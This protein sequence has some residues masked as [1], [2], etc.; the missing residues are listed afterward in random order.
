MRFS[1]TLRLNAKP[2][3]WEFYVPY[4]QLKRR[5]AN[6]KYIHDE[7]FIKTHSIPNSSRD[8]GEGSSDDERDIESHGDNVRPLRRT[9]SARVLAE[10]RADSE[11]DL[12]TYGS[13][14]KGPAFAFDLLLPID[15][16][17]GDARASFKEQEKIFFEVLENSKLQVEKFFQKL[18]NTL[19]SVTTEIEE[20]AS[21]IMVQSDAGSHDEMEVAPLLI[22]NI[23]TSGLLS[24]SEFRRRCREH[25]IELG[26]AINFSNLNRA[27]FD[28]IL[29]KHDKCTGMSKREAFMMKLDAESLFVDLRDIKALQDTTARVYA[30]LFMNGNVDGAEKELNEHL[31]DLIV[32]DRSTIWQQA[33]RTERRVSVFHAIRG[34][35]DVDLGAAASAVVWRPQ[36]IPVLTAILLFFIILA[37]PGVIP[38]LLTEDGPNYPDSTLQAAHRCLALT[39]AVV[40]L[41]ASEGIPL[42]VTSFL[43]VPG[44]ILLRVFIGSS[45]EPLDAHSAS[46]EVFHNLSSDTLLLIICVYA[47]GAAL[48][49]FDIDKVVATAVLS[50]VRKPQVLLLAVMGLGVVVSM[51]VSN[52]AAPVLLNSVMMPTI[53]GLRNTPGSRP[54]VECLLLGIMASSNIGGFASPISS[55]QSAVALGLLRGENSISFA[56]WLVAALPLCAVMVIAFYVALF[57]I[58]RP[59]DYVLPPLVIK[60]EKFERPHYIVSAT[61]V[62]TVVLWACHPLSKSFGSPGVVAV[63]PILALFGSGILIKEDFNNLPW[64]VV[65][66][67]AGGVVL[68]AAVKSCKLLDLIALKFLSVLDHGDLRLTYSVFCLFMALV[69]NFV[70]HTVSAIVVLP[71]VFSIGVSLGH[72][73]LM[74][75]AGTFAASSAMALPISS[76]PNISAIQ[77]EDETG[78]AYLSTRDILRIGTLMT[79]LATVVLLTIGY[80]I[81]IWLKL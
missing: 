24:P 29:K 72:P 79:I 39:A 45:G 8:A 23:S 27:A 47:L 13:V 51:F 20:E 46:Q 15:A 50:R 58:Y 42:Y 10:I 80:N 66:L 12:Q 4:D 78:K 57:I 81:M 33:L 49:K 77:V 16:T 69:A 68:G 26:D 70:S 41:W 60:T 34:G 61:L 54:F 38:A 64:D 28:K 32:W 65:Y 17:E 75:L 71:L 37:F 25:Y 11:R 9:A 40:S 2:D 43:V 6:L 5:V 3:W 18:S 14:K 36:F 52:V 19:A 56:K 35:A 44:T 30:S 55:P 73:K 21:N 62:I 63:I 59:S 67:V 1:D 76:F 74:V 53:N 31:R 7:I 48:S 22:P